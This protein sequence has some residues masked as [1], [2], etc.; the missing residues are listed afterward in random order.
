MAQDS[1]EKWEAQGRVKHVMM[2][3]D[4]FKKIMLLTVVWKVDS[5][6]QG[7]LMGGETD[8]RRVSASSRVR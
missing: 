8:A 7:G 1:G 4:V 3:S 5:R 2:D 6:G